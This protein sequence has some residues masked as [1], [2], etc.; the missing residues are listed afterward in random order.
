MS[1][2]VSDVKRLFLRCRETVTRLLPAGARCRSGASWGNGLNPHTLDVPQQ[3]PLVTD[4]AGLVRA[5]PT[6][7]SPQGARNVAFE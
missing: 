4:H 7:P 5:N 6:L 2:H 3:S 1:L